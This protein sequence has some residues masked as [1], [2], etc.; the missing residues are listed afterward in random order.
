MNSQT[1]VHITVN[2]LVLIDAPHSALN[3]L[4]QAEGVAENL[5]VIKAIQ[6]GGNT[7]PYVSAQAWR[8]WWRNVLVSERKWVPSPIERKEKIA[9]TQAQP[10]KYPDD[11]V[12]GYMRAQAEEVPVID[13]NTGKPQL[14]EQGQPKLKKGKD[15]TLTRVSPLKCSPLVSVM[16]QR[17]IRDFGVMSRHE[18]Y[19]VPH[20]H[21]FYSTVLKGIFSL[22][23][24]TLGRFEQSSKTGFQNISEDGLKLAQAAGATVDGN[25]AEMPVKVRQERATDTLAV[26]PYLTGGANQTLHLTDV[27]PKLVILTVLLGG[28]HLFMNVIRDERGQARININ[29]L[30]EVSRV[31]KERLLT[32]VFIGRREGFLDEQAD[33]LNSL[34]NEGTGDLPAIHVAELNSMVERF[35][36]I[37]PSVVGHA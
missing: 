28:N 10:W 35:C 36:Q 24:T 37:L 31:F 27:A 14:D 15:I 33:E 13:K 2:G 11:D 16:A 3:M 12:F 19:P 29:A 9:F 34:A 7:Y 20:E 5:V 4:G 25:K 26:L 6:R 21:Q 30:K 23:L 18:G 1:K 22:D 32:P 17:P 8:Y